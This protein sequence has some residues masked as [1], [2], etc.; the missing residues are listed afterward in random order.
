M[1]QIYS[2]VRW[3][4]T[5]KKMAADG[6]SHLVECGPGKILTGLNKRIIATVKTFAV[7]DSATL[8]QALTAVSK[9]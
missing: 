4:E 9:S 1:K 7:F 2:P 3:V 8:Q 5:I 6:V